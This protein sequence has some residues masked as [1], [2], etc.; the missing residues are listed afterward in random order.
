M[1]TEITVGKEG[2]D[3]LVEKRTPATTRRRASGRARPRRA[4][5]KVPAGNAAPAAMPPA[6]VVT[7]A[8]FA[9]SQR[10]TVTARWC[11]SATTQG[12]LPL[13]A[14]VDRYNPKG[15]TADKRFAVGDVIRVRV[16]DYPKDKPPMLALE[17][18]PQAAVVVLDPNTREVKAIVGGYG[19]RPGG[20]DRALQAK[21]QPGSS[22]KPFVY[23]AAFAT[24]KWTPA[25]VLIDG[26][27]TYASPGLAPWKPQ[28]AEKEEFLGPVRLRVALAQSL[29][30]VASQL[31]DTSRGG[32][33][34]AGGGVT[35]A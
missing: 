2:G 30:T 33:D 25:S 11:R 19:Y 21:R 7:D 26:P 34:P 13:P 12:W 6:S 5:G 28:N 10:T 16:I 18:G 29:N 22:F 27:Q 3:E 31:V 24:E 32:V 20:F 23:T 17:L 35:G 14:A 9:R 8:A 4:P 15:L 1:I